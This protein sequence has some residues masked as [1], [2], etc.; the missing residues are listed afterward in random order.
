VSNPFQ[1]VWNPGAMA[2]EVERRFQN[3]VAAEFGEG[4]IVTLVSQ[5]ERSDASHAH[6]FAWLREAWLSLPEA[7]ADQFPTSDHL[8][9]RALI[10]AGFYQE[11]IVDAGSNA[12]ALR[13][14]GFVRSIDGFA[15]VVVR[16]PLVVTRWAKSQSRR[17]MDKAEFQASKQ[18]IIDVVSEMLGVTPEQLTQ[19]R[20]A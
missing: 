3:A 17:S 20:A 1:A 5:H 7:L 18:G 19:A 9:K 4:E 10:L 16:G 12:A 2:F 11:T 14:A 8:R 15:H 13:V 6:E